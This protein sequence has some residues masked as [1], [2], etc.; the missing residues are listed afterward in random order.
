VRPTRTIIDRCFDDPTRGLS[1]SLADLPK[2]LAVFRNHWQ[3]FA[4]SVRPVSPGTVAA[5]PDEVD[6]ATLGKLN[7]HAVAA[8][9]AASPAQISEMHRFGNGWLVE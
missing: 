1:K 2:S 9:A 7:S 3:T 4:D 8:M 6:S 5:C